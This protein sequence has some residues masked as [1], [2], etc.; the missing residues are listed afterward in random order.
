MT[1][2]LAL[3]YVAA[4]VFFLVVDAIWLKLAI[5]PVFERHVGDLLAPD[6]RLSAAAGFY[7]FYVAGI[8]YFCTLPGLKDDSLALAFGNGLVL[9]FLA[10]GTYEATNMATLKG[11]SWSM[12]MLD[13]GWGM[14]LTGTT[15]TVG[16]L[17]GS[18]LGI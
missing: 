7:L 10:Y 11:W 13:T 12:V 9:G 17:L 6:I 14:I 1:F 3:T 5:S 18:R 15:A 16:Y 4:A 8:L 2:S